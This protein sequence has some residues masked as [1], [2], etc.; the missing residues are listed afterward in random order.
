MT[1]YFE[2]DGQKLTI[3]EDLQDCLTSEERKLGCLATEIHFEY[4][5]ESDSLIKEEDL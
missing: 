5:I 2:I 4:L 1:R 3:N